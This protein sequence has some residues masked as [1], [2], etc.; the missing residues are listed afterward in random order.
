[1]S[2]GE[3][4]RELREARGLTQRQLASSEFSKSYISLIEHG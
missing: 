2:L 3:R 4:L 1:M